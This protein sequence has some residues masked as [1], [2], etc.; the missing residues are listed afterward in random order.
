[1][2]VDPYNDPILEEFT[3]DVA[4]LNERARAMER[5]ERLGCAI[6]PREPYRTVRWT[7]LVFPA[8]MVR[9]NEEGRLKVK[10]PALFKGRHL[11]FMRGWLDTLLVRQL[12]VE[13]RPQKIFVDMERGAIASLIDR[14][15]FQT[16]TVRAGEEIELVVRNDSN[17][18]GYVDAAIAGIMLDSE[19][20]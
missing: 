15:P 19:T 5:A 11:C 2:P 6:A 14:N 8:V 18:D 1:M 17:L 16:E 13:G 3:R 7:T 10:V 20:R 12:L 9:S 4:K